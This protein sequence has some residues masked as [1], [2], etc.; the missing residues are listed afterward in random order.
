MPGHP[1]ERDRAPLVGPQPKQGGAPFGL[2]RLLEI[3]GFTYYGTPSFSILLPCRAY[4]PLWG[5][6]T[7]RDRIQCTTL[8]SRIH[9]AVMVI[10]LALGIWLSPQSKVAC[11]TGHAWRHKNPG[12]TISSITD[13]GHPGLWSL[14]PSFSLPKASS[15]GR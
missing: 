11:W 5:V 3:P 14:F 10:Y 8:Q 2:P 1:L 9:R 7:T 6:F 4:S 13:S 15:K 12:N